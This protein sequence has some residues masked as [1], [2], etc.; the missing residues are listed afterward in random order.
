VILVRANYG[1]SGLALAQSL[2]I[3]LSSSYRFLSIPSIYSKNTLNYL[4]NAFH[5]LTI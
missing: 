1:A 3:E 4:G 2:K 5:T